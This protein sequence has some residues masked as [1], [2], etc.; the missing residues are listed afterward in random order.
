MGRLLVF[1]LIESFEC[2]WTSDSV[3]KFLLKYN[4]D[5]FICIYSYFTMRGDGLKG[6]LSVCLA[7][8]AMA[9]DI[10]IPSLIFGAPP[11]GWKQQ[12]LPLHPPPHESNWG[13]RGETPPPGGGLLFVICIMM[14]D[15]QTALRISLFISKPQCKQ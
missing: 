11:S 6:R 7:R 5:K 2:K 9:C 14:A 10:I 12:P 3:S 8:N 1:L 4:P 15:W 13:R